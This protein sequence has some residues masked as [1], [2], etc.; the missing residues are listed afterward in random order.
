MT[1]QR[2][3]AVSAAHKSAVPVSL[4]SSVFLL[5]LSLC[6]NLCSSIPLPHPLVVSRKNAKAKHLNCKKN[7]FVGKVCTLPACVSESP[8]CV[9]V[10]NVIKLV[11]AGEFCNCVEEATSCGCKSPCLAARG[12]AGEA[13]LARLRHCTARQ[14]AAG[15]CVCVCSWVC[16]GVSVCSAAY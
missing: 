3:L 14:M 6:H 12:G 2:Q 10:W 16:A 7:T 4:F 5:P 8:V 9:Y 1:T 13:A 11:C 15:V